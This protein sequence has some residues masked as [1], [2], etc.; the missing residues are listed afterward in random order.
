MMELTKKSLV[1]RVKTVAGNIS[2]DNLFLLSS[3]ISYYSA[4]ALAPFALILLAVASLLGQGMQRDIV[5]QAS[6]TMGAE[7]GQ[8]L[9][10]VFSN[11][12]EGVN[13]GSISGIIGAVILLSTASM[14]FLQFR[15]SFDVIYGYYDPKATKSVMD[16]V[17]E[18]LFAM[19]FILMTAVVFI[20]SLFASGIFLEI[21]GGQGNGLWSTGVVLYVNFLI[22]LGMFTAVHYYVPSKK[23]GMVDT[24]KKASLTAIFFM[25]GNFLL[26]FYLKKVA[27][28]SV[29]GAAGAILVFLTWSYY[30]SFIIFLSVEVFEYMKK[31]GK[32]R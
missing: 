11:V 10:M 8:M 16:S 13:V 15:Y 12:N 20:L 29:Y 24:V 18:K 2:E 4:L 31:I 17:K 23:K 5:Q 3:S 27:A 26:A 14:V 28:D 7:V 22:Y 19:F 6:A 9:K 21:F 25:L 1:A 32:V 30:S